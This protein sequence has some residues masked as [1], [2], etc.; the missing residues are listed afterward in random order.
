M[1]IP[2]LDNTVGGS[3]ANTYVT[4]LEA[5]NYHDSRLNSSAW[6]NAEADNKKRSH[7][8][9]AKRLDRENWQGDRA[10]SDQ[11]LAWPRAGVIKPDG[12]GVGS[13]DYIPGA[14]AALYPR[15][16]YGFY[17]GGYGEQ[18]L[19]TEIPQPV[20]DAQCEL[21]LAYLEGFDESGEG[22]MDSFSAEGVSV[23]FRSEKPSG[24]LPPRVMQLIGGL[25]AGN[26]LIR[27]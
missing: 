1:A 21:A 9:A 19:S 2:A 27:G 25:I 11:V 8:M 16:G 10:T 13:G 12:V 26:R 23:K 17:W 22:A 15:T 3:A 6:T 18:Y 24:G 20:K 5:E 7:L 14:G 4:E